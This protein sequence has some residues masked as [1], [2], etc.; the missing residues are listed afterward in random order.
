V[1]IAALDAGAGGSNTGAG[2][3]GLGGSV[4]QIDITN[5]GQFV[6]DVKAGDGGDGKKAG[7]GGSVTHVT[8]AGDIGDFTSDF[9]MVSDTSGMGGISAGEKGAG[10][11]SAVNGSITNITANRIAA[12]LAGAPAANGIVY[13]NAVQ[14]IAKISA[15]VLGADVNGDGSFNFLPDSGSNTTFQPDDSHDPTDGDIAVDGLV[16]V[17]AAGLIGTFPVTPLKLITV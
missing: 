15:A 10:A 9:G 4:S 1:G 6:R 17:R 3:G 11:G 13:N 5:V 12:M 14:T 2:T 7:G 8:V 16:L